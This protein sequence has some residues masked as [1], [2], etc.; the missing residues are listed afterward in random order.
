[1]Y[2][3]LIDGKLVYAPNPLKSGNYKIYNPKPEH[4]EAEGYLEVIEADYPEVAE[5][6]V[7]YY[8]KHY[9]ERNGKIYGEWVEVEAPEDVPTQPTLEERT[10]KLETEVDDLGEALNMILEGVTE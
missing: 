7:K 5:G 3:K 1:M 2:G 4:Y 8:E 10:A 9:V 6:E